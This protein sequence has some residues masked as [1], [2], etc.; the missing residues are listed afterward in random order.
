MY[1]LASTI[2]PV[3]TSDGAII[4]YEVLLIAGV[5]VNMLRHRK[6]NK[7]LSEMLSLQ[8]DRIREEKLDV[9]LQNQTYKA[10]YDDNRE[11]VSVQIEVTGSLSKQKHLIHVY[12]R[13]EIGRD[14]R[15]KIILNDVEAAGHQLQL[16]RV[17]KELFVRNMEPDIAV[18][19][20]RGKKRYPITPE[21][22]CIQ[23][24]DQLYVAKTVLHFTM[25]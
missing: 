23:S 25:I 8:K 6:K 21:P 13:A 9:M 24:G 1:M 17:K 20:K 10:A 18:E 19:L 4:T 22:V 14:D 16:L 12:D 11:H 3:L 5:A 7:D 15:N 2:I